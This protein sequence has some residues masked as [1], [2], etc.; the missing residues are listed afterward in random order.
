MMAEERDDLQA[1]PASAAAVPSSVTVAGHHEHGGHT[2]YHLVCTGLSDERWVLPRRLADIRSQLH[3]PVKEALGAE[4]PRIFHTTRFAQ[5]GGIP[6]TT[7]RL[8]AWLRTLFAA[9]R[10][11][12]LQGRGLAAVA[13]FLARPPPGS[14]AAAALGHPPP[15]PGGAPGGSL[16][17]CT[18]SR[19]LSH[20]PA[21]AGAPADRRRASAPPS[22][23]GGPSFLRRRHDPLAAAPAAAHDWESSVAEWGPPPPAAAPAGGAGRPG[24][25]AIR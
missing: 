9:I 7:E 25:V 4:Y 11:G 16:A 2:L 13:A 12:R 18:V 19:S 15:A 3:G 14:E 5:Y 22:S 23:G 8:N 21:A 20:A 1:A 17:G 6:G 24:K 10:G